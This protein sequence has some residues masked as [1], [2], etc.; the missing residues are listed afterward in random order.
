MKYRLKKKRFKKNILAWT[1]TIFDFENKRKREA[2][3]DKV[4]KN[5][6]SAMKLWDTK[7]HENI[8]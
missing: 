2:H 3:V 7:R 4:F 1:Y 8:I 5:Y 6:K